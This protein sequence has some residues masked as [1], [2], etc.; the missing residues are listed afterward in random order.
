MD[1][2]DAD[3]LTQGVK[4]GKCL[5][6]RSGSSPCNKAHVAAP[7]AG[8]TTNRRAG[9]REIRTSGSEGGGS[10][11]NR[12]SL[13]LFRHGVLYMTHEVRLR[14]LAICGS[15]R[16][17]SSNMAVIEAAKLL[18]PP[19]LEIEIFDG[20]AALPH[21]N[22]D[23]DTDDP[24]RTVLT[25]RHAVGRADALLIC[26]PEYARGVA[27]V[28][29]NGLDW[30]VASLEF[31]GKPVAV[32][33]AS[34]RATHADAALRLTLATMSARLIEPA[35]IALPLRGRNLDAE[36]IAADRDLSSL[37]RQALEG[38]TYFLSTHT[39]KSENQ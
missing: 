6:S 25:L 19:P 4:G 11:A 32:I 2:T 39:R 29:K 15:L 16:T 12:Y 9:C 23:L 38:M 34:P 31:P 33:N 7:L 37:M 27:G 20:L 14:I 30:L 17:R 3:C 22:P 26:S 8:K 21:Y 24:P 18:A 10:E 28:M 1:V 35:S 5:V 36:A 13:P